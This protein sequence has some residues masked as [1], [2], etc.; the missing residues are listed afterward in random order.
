MAKSFWSIENNTLVWRVADGE[1]HTD[2]IEMSGLRCDCIVSYGV[3]EDGSLA[4]SQKCFFPALRTIP[5]NTHATY[6]FA[7]GEDERVR[8]L[9][10]GTPVREYP[11]VFRFD[12]VLTVESKTDGKARIV[13]RFFPSADLRFAVEL[14]RITAEA[15]ADWSLSAPAEAVHAYGRGTKGVYLSKI[16]HSAPD[17]M[18]LPAGESVEFAIFYT[19]VIANET[20]SLPDGRAELEKRMARVTALCDGALVLRTGNAELD[21]MTRFAKLRAGESIFE[22]LT[23]KY[24]SP[25]GQAYYAAIWCNDEIEY[26]GPHFAMTG[27]PIALEASRNAY[28]AYI[29]FMSDAYLPLPSSIIAEGLDIWETRR[30]T[31][32][33]LRFSACMPAT[34]RSRGNCSARFDGARNTAKGGKR[35]RA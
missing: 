16:Y 5:N 32:T 3:K 4:L 20:L 26:A 24:H 13:R 21:T 23:G 7:L 17:V 30:C 27:D 14:V 10:N 35:P 15:A 28:R 31:C 8:L 6:C 33:A 18:P 9:R 22:T 12:G 29:P 11:E 19:A 2:D 34:R 25:G 1:P